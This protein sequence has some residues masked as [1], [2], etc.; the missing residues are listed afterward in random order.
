MKNMAAQMPA[1]NVVLKWFGVFMA[2]IVVMTGGV[3]FMLM[4]PSVSGELKQSA[5][6]IF[7]VV[8]I[9]LWLGV[10]L[11]FMARRSRKKASRVSAATVPVSCPT[12]GAN[13]RLIAGDAA[14]ACAYCS[15]RLVPSPAVMMEVLEAG[16]RARREAGMA[17][18]RAKRAV[19]LSTRNAGV[20]P[21][22]VVLGSWGMVAM[23]GLGSF[24]VSAGLEGD[25]HTMAVAALVMAAMALPVLLFLLWRVLR[26]ERWSSPLLDLEQQFSGR[27]S[28]QLKD[29]V[30]WLNAYWAETYSD[31]WIVGVGLRFGTLSATVAGYP[32]LLDAHPEKPYGGARH[33]KGFLPRLNILVAA[34]LPLEASLSR[35]PPEAQVHEDAIRKMGFRLRLSTSGIL[36]TAQP[37]MLT[38][39]MKQPED[40]HA[41]AQTFQS[42]AHLAAY[43]GPPAAPLP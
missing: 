34:E 19:T 18:L 23:L 43:V 8:A 25:H 37:I 16:N 36:A 14:A 1:S 39:L 41:L 32:M 28:T 40:L 4:N 24:V 6:M 35:L 20:D 5:L 26:R 33:A 38:H 31:F 27:Y 17:Q 3:Q 11:F 2:V 15:S 13:N 10:P 9:G 21:M 29:Q 42:L 22:K 7:P 12:C 30:A